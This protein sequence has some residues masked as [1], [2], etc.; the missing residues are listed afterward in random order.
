[1][2]LS[3]DNK[4]LKQKVNKTKKARNMPPSRKRR[5]LSTTQKQ[6]PLL[7]HRNVFQVSLLKHKRKIADINLM[8]RYYVQQRDHLTVNFVL[9]FVHHIADIH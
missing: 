5:K 6:Y 4:Y 8:A 1:M 2:S 7:S 3:L 9:K